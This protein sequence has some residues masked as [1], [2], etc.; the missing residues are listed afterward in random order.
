MVGS[1]TDVNGI[2]RRTLEVLADATGITLSVSPSGSVYGKTRFKFGSIPLGLKG[3]LEVDIVSSFVNPTQ[4]D[5][6][7]ILHVMGDLHLFVFASDYHKT[8]AVYVLG[9]DEKVQDYKGFF[10]AKKV[11]SLLQADTVLPKP[12]AKFQ[13]DFAETHWT[14][15]SKK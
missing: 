15:V 13:R 7:L 8:V 1:I 14:D 11:T 6:G 12:A 5:V 3:S 9:V 4:E 10:E 2:E